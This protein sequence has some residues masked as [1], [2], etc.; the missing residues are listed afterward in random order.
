[1][2]DQNAIL[3]R[4]G[5]LQA[6][7]V[8]KALNVTD[9]AIEVGMLSALPEE[10]CAKVGVSSAVAEHVVDDDD[11]G[12]GYSDDSALLSTAGCD[13]AVLS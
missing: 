7:F 3:V 8:S 12:V 6:Y 4:S 5:G 1:M 11:D 10:G 13:A 9:G 2:R